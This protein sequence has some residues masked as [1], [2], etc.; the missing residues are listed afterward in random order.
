MITLKGRYNS[1]NIMLPDENYL[2]EETK[3]I[4]LWLFRQYRKLLILK[5]LLNQF[6]ILKQERKKLVKFLQKKV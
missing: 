3:R 2:D 1:A 4:K 6:I 5:S